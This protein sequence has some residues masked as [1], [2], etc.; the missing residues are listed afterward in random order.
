MPLAA[1]AAK[2][3]ELRFPAKGTPYAKARA[4]LLKQGLA[5]DCDLKPYKKRRHSEADCEEDRALFLETD[6][7][8]WRSYVIV[9]VDPNDDTV[10]DAHYP[11]DVE[12][13]PG[14]PPPLAADVPQLKGSYRKARRVLQAQGFRPARNHNPVPWD[15]APEAQCSGTGMAF[16]KAY[17]ISRQGRVL[18]I[19]TIGENYQ[20]YFV[21]WSAWKDLKRDFW[22]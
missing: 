8:G 10:I 13:L 21:E 22:R 20:I 6:E 16:C 17:W 5:I 14:I 2:H 7:R 12:G 11:Y 3:H 19:N 1:S 15:V 4:E 9:Y 18:C